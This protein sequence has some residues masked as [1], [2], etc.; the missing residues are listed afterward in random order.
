MSREARKGSF[1]IVTPL[2]DGA[3]GDMR[4]RIARQ[5]GVPTSA[6][7]DRE[8][9]VIRGMLGSGAGDN[10][11]SR[12]VASKYVTGR[13][14]ETA[15]QYAQSLEVMFG[16]GIKASSYGIYMPSYLRG[17]R[18]QK[19]RIGDHPHAA[20]LIGAY[21]TDTIRE[22][23]ATVKDVYANSYCEVID[24]AG[25]RT[26]E[27]SPDLAHFQ[28]GNGLDLPFA[29][30]SV[31]S[32]HTNY[33]LRMLKDETG[34]DAPEK[35]TGIFQQAANVL[36]PEGVLLMVERITIPHDQLRKELYDAGFTH[37]EICETEH[38]NNRYAMELFLRS[39]AASPLKGTTNKVSNSHFIIA[40]K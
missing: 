22:Y 26:A 16:Q 38:F 12:K 31:D 8:I 20:L 5:A 32:V 17:L 29:K 24:V 34:K 23:V 10:P 25:G 33:L 2:N 36:R 40:R 35:R 9:E 14:D 3:R 28:Y 27:T 39:T 19:D 1:H 18:S 13:I 30:G 6:V 21:T 37:V 4:A 11:F 15:Q 7:D